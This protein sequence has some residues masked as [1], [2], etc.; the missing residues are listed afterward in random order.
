[1]ESVKKTFENWLNE[2]D[3]FSFKSY[4]NLP[5]IELYMD[6]VMTYLEKQLQIF[7]TSS[8]D[9]Q[10]TPSMINNYVKGEVIPAPISKR[11]GKEHLAI[12]EEVCTLKQVLS[13][14][15]VKQIL[16]IRYK[17]VIKKAD[18]FNKFNDLNNKLSDQAVKDAFK[19][20]NDIKDNDIL[21]LTNLSMEFALIANSYINISKRIL[22]LIRVFDDLNKLKQEK[23]KEN[24]NNEN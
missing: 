18:T 1:M 4:E 17:D 12:I 5:D 19:K 23:E 16:D 24:L 13:I 2:F 3:N 14:A 10:I 7:Q 15:E 8:L 20:L 6:Q 21:G 11:Y 9:K 22:F